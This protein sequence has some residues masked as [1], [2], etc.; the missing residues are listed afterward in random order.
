ML[1]PNGY[2]YL[3]GHSVAALQPDDRCDW[4][5]GFWEPEGLVRPSA[6]ERKAL[7]VVCHTVVGAGGLVVFA[8]CR[9]RTDDDYWLK[10]A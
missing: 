3:V 8:A 10:R 5:V 1:K 4:L 6:A 9:V 7:M 2:L